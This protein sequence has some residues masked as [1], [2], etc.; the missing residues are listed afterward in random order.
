MCVSCV[1]MC[2]FVFVYMCVLCEFQC[3]QL[4]VHAY[5]RIVNDKMKPV[6]LSGYPRLP[7]NLSSFLVPAFGHYAVGA[8]TDDSKTLVFVHQTMGY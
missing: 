7:T 6:T 5:V 1:Y 4:Q 8:L 2:V 3:V